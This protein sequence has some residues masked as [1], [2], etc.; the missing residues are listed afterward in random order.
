MKICDNAYCVV[1]TASVTQA[2]KNRAIQPFFDLKVTITAVQY[3]IIEVARSQ[4]VYTDI[5]DGYTW[6]TP[7]EARYIKD[8]GA[9]PP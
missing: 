7:E 3:N 4:I 1:P 6:Y 8:N 5:F 9:W 2:M